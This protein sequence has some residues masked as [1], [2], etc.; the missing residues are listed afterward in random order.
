MACLRA[1]FPEA[2]LKQRWLRR[3]SETALTKSS[4][5]LLEFGVADA[6]AWEAGLSCGGRIEVLV[7]ALAAPLATS[8]LAALTARE[9]KVHLAAA[10]GSRRELIS[11]AAARALPWAAPALELQEPILA[12][13]A[14]TRILVEPL[15]PARRLLIIGATHITQALAPMATA[16]GFEVTVV[17]PRAAWA[18][19]ERFPDIELIKSWPEDYL[20]AHPPDAAT[21]VV[22]LSHDPKIDDPA[23]LAALAAK[24]LLLAALGSKQTHAARL[25]RLAAEGITQQA[26]SQ[27]QAPAG[28]AIGARGHAEIAV[29]VLA[30]VI[31]AWRQKRN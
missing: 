18:R 1:R 23:L 21:A 11:W 28:L 14:G 20:R 4:S 29:S 26:L 15:L 3:R 31:A 17:D 27:I 8:M 5:C 7:E 6:T 10:D 25:V 16:A 12:T 24:P 9:K 13:V 22:T 2:A 30:S 19:P